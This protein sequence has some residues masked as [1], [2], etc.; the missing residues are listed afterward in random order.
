MII[1]LLFSLLKNK[2]EGGLFIVLKTIFY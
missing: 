2:H 1:F